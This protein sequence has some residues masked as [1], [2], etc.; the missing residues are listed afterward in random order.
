[1]INSA[2]NFISLLSQTFQHK[3]SIWKM[4]IISLFYLYILKYIFHDMNKYIL[5]YIFHDMNKYILKYIYSYHEIYILKYI[6]SYHE[7]YILKYIN[8]IEI[9]YTFSILIL[10]VGMFGLVEK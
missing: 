8:K 10:C 9:L 3:E 7:I 4:C 5:K 2:L 6:Y 1:M